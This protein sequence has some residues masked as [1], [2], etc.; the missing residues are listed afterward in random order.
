[1]FVVSYICRLECY[2]PKMFFWFAT[3]F[4][5]VRNVLIIM[6]INMIYQDQ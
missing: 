1:M 6:C 2:L 3:Y 5:S 4:R